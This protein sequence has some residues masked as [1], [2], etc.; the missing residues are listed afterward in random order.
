MNILD[1]YGQRQRTSPELFDQQFEYEIS[2]ASVRNRTLQRR[3]GVS[4]QI[5]DRSKWQRRHEVVCAPTQDAHRS[6]ASGD[7]QDGK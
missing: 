5:S 6:A 7:A 2:L 4:G 3:A 1:N